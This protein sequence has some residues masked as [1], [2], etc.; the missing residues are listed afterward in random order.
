MRSSIIAFF[1]LF[2]FSSAWAEPCFDDYAVDIYVGSVVKP[3]KQSNS[4]VLFKILT[5]AAEGGV[6]FAGKYVVFHYSC[7]GGCITGGILDVTTGKLTAEFPEELVAGD[8]PETFRSKYR[9]DSRLILIQGTSAYDGE[10]QKQYYELLDG[11]LVAV[12]K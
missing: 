6:N 11:K 1:L 3:E 10:F 2:C 9:K 7:G 12:E 8:E 4:D 5:E